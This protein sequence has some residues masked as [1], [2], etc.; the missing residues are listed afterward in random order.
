[1]TNGRETSFENP[2]QYQIRISNQ[3]SV[4]CL[5]LVLAPQQTNKQKKVY[6]ARIKNKCLE[7]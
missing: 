1:M 2:T 4:H 5:Q 3:P 6:E 7:V